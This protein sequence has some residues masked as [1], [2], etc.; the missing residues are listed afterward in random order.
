MTVVVGGC[1]GDGRGGRR[2]SLHITVKCE[3]RTWY[4]M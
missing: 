2:Q 3:T 4:V 1:G